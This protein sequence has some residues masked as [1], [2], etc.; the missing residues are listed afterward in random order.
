MSRFYTN[1]TSMEVNINDVTIGLTHTWSAHKIHSE[2]MNRVINDLLD[3]ETS[4]TL[5]EGQFLR[6]DEVNKVWTNQTVSFT[7][8]LTGLSDTDI[9]TV[10]NGQFLVYDSAKKKWINKT[11]DIS[12]KMKDLQDVDLTGI[13]NGDILVYNTLNSKFVASENSMINLSDFRTSIINQIKDGTTVAWSS[14]SRKFLLT[15]LSLANL[16]DV[17]SSNVLEEQYLTYDSTLGKYVFKKI[18]AKANLLDLLDVDAKNIQEGQ[19]LVYDS[20]N[21]K[22][23]PKDIEDD[24]LDEDAKVVEVTQNNYNTVYNGTK[25][26]ALRDIIA[27]VASP[28]EVL[29]S[30]PYTEEFNLG[31]VEVLKYEIGEIVENVAM[32]F[33]DADKYLFNYDDGYVQF[34]GTLHLVH[35]ETYQPYSVVEQDDGF[36]Y[37]FAIDLKENQLVNLSLING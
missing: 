30:I 34:D 29:I 27:S 28:Y 14:V 1:T 3:V 19:S 17:I 10:T 12:S 2:I 36:L 26:V 24:G 6:Y 37:S 13:K 7:T 5:T 23:I 32:N 15:E 35:E 33:S 4:G 31:K 9:G 25:Q 16:T 20:I 21:R 8:S 11:F 18:E 22:F